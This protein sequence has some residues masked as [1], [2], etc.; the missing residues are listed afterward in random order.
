MF[1]YYAETDTLIISI[2]HWPEGAKTYS[3]GPFTVTISELGDLVELEIR[4]AS[5]FLTRALA[6]GVPTLEEEEERG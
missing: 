6:E 5:H 2:R 4:S 3:S 1:E